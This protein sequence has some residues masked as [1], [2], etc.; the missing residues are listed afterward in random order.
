MHCQQ[1]SIVRA[2]GGWRGG[3]VDT[4]RGESVLAVCVD[5]SLVPSPSSGV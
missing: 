4:S 3:G 2:V 5:K 1:V